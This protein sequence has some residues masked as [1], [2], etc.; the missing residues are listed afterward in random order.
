MV[1]YILFILSLIYGT[2]YLGG[3]FYLAAGSSLYGLSFR[4]IY[5][6][7]KYRIEELTGFQFVEG[8]NLGV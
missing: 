7:G 3:K 4:E 5:E 1:T 8:F 6:V 2:S